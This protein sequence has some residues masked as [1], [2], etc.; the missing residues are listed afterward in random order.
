MK[1]YTGLYIF[2]ASAKDEVL[3]KQI[4]K[5]TGEI[6][7]L[8]GNILN[9]EVLGKKTFA[10]PMHKRDAGVYVRVRFEADPSAIATLTHRYHLMDEVFRVQFN[11]VD[12]RRE[13]KIAK[14]T[15]AQKAREE[16]R[17]A[18]AAAAAAAQAPAAEEKTE[19]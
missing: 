3:D 16:A 17:A 4:E 5:A 2:A 7:R 19:A 18:A 1:T 9:T 6:T 15:E 10:R 14:Q 11:V 8:S 12:E 13:S